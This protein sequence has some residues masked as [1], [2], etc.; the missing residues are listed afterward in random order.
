MTQTP[1]SPDYRRRLT[2]PRPLGEGPST[3]WA[4]IVNSVAFDH[5]R[6]CDAPLLAE[7]C[8][9]AH[10]A[11]QA[12]VALAKG[13]PVSGGKPSP[14]LTVQ[15]KSVRAMTALSARL[16]L[17]PQSRFDRL[18]AGTNSRLGDPS[19]VPSKLDKF[20]DPPRQKPLTGLAKFI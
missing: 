12:A 20:T 7:Y 8:R 16:R 11:D 3:I 6:E 17:C 2:P 15:E 1:S 14:W 13:G 9:A 19:A 5:F 18:K 4:Y 10:Q